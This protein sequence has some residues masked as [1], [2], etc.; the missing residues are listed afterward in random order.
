MDGLILV[1]GRGG[2]AN[3]SKTKHDL[4]DILYRYSQMKTCRYIKTDN[5]VKLC[6]KTHMNSKLKIRQKQSNNKLIIKSLITQ[7]I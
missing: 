6:K 4:K 7:S 5:T 2:P 1:E 3:T